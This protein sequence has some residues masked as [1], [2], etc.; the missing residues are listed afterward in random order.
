[1]GNMRKINS[2]HALAAIYD[3]D[4]ALRLLKG[5]KKN[6]ETGC[7]EWQRCKDEHGYGK[8]WYDG[9]SQWVH[10]ISYAI[11]KGEIPE[12]MTVDHDC[13]NRPCCNPD[14]LGIMS[15]SDNSKKR[16]ETCRQ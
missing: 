13:C 2:G 1:M 3:R 16:W 10:R 8:M 15:M 6:D 14:H 12:G 11:F 4:V 7:W 9:K 5:V